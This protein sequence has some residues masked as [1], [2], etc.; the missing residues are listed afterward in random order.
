MYDLVLEVIHELSKNTPYGTFLYYWVL[1][2]Y[3]GYWCF[4][5]VV[6]AIEK[7][8]T[9]LQTSLESAV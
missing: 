3:P 5:G 4:M 7:Y 8:E 9:N 1:C 2:L 6:R